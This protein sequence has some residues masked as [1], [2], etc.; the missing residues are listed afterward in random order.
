MQVGAFGCSS[1]FLYV[2]DMLVKKVCALSMIFH[3]KMPTLQIV[4]I[5][6]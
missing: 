4:K 1:C 2:I 6:V 5:F 3:K